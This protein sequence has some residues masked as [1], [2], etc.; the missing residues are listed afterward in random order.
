MR[1]G[2]YADYK[3]YK[4]KQ[5][6]KKR[7]KTTPRVIAFDLDET[8]GSFTDLEI[9]WSGLQDFSDDNCPV[10]F[11]NLLDLY[12]EFLRYGIIPILEYLIEKKKTGECGSIY[13]YTN[14]Q[15]E[16]NWVDLISQY[17]NY[18]LKVKGNIFNQII[19]AFKIN[20][21][22]VEPSRTTHSKTYP[23]FI[24]CTLL[25][26]NT[27]IFFLDN[28]NYPEMK[29]GRVY[30]IQPKSYIHHLSTN[31]IIHRFVS[32]KLRLTLPN[33]TTETIQT[34]LLTYFIS[35]DTYN[36]GNP[37]IRDLETDILVA[38]KIMYHLR[39]FFYIANK[40]ARTKKKRQRLGRSTRKLII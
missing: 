28:A 22:R 32:S 14:N 31:D 12:P 25:P 1:T 37:R 34:H 8:L 2:I 26:K 36:T 11:N 19:S 7:L 24:R 10:S 15:C 40:L 35:R 30:Y 16:P 27:E 17:L 23:D 39:D 3:I 29:Q 18:K 9:L 6:Y 38:Q 13:I 33:A 5:F 4:G 21:R 20:N